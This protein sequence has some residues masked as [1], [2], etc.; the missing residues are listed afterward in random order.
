MFQFGIGG[1]LL[2]PYG[3][4]LAANPTPYEMLTIMDV[5]VDITQELKDLTGQYKFPDDVA[6]GL[7]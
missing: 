1:L 6:P 7:W 4:N 3:G 5:S 2:N